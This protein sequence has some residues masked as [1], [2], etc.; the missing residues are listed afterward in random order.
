M[1]SSFNNF[2]LLQRSGVVAK[3][4]PMEWSLPINTSLGLYDSLT[5]EIVRYP[6]DFA[7]LLQIAIL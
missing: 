1:K 3:E 2:H 6:G 4:K 7:L 5:S